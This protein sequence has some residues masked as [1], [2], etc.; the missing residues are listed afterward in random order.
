MQ[1]ASAGNTCDVSAVIYII[2]YVPAQQLFP[3]SAAGLVEPC[4]PTFISF[5]MALSPFVLVYALRV[6][7][8]GTVAT[9]LSYTVVLAGG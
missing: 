8:L 1:L 7:V 5:S 4:N 2:S 3:A 9:S 6:D